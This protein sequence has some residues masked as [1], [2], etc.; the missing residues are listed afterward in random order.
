MSNEYNK[1]IEEELSTYKDQLD[2]HEL[3]EIYHYWSNKYLKNMFSEAGFLGIDDLFAK[4]MFKS[5]AECKVDEPI[6]LS[7]GSG[8]CDVEVRVA[9]LLK[10]KGL[11]KF[12]IECLELN[13]NMIERGKEFAKRENMLEHIIFTEVD[14][15]KWNADKQ[16]TSIM[17]NQSLHHVLDLEHLFKEVEK[18]LLD[19]GSFV[20]SDIMGRN[21]HQRWPEALTHVHKLWKELPNEYKY[22]HLMKRNEE[23]YVNHDCSTEGFEGIRAQDILALLVEYFNFELFVGFGNVIDVFV[24][25]PF[26]HNFNPLKKIDTDFID[27]VHEIDE[28]GILHGDLTP[29]HIICSVQK[30]KVLKPIYSRNISPERCIRKV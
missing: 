4:Y 22:N 29:T 18:S 23:E 26:G 30:H 25:R 20:I 3:P 2:V 21:G 13:S 16:Y 27:H 11:T 24:D 14:F 5:V 8:N 28:M 1:K 10:N 6:F 9:K 7:I 19:N 15:N 12:K 17:A